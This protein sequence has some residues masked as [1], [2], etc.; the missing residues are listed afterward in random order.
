MFPQNVY[1]VIL[2]FTEFLTARET[3]VA[4]VN[5]IILTVITN[6][7]VYSD[8]SQVH[9]VFNCLVSEGVYKERNMV[10]YRDKL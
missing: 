10:A 7:S 6:L 5:A 8:I 3:A 1:A 2:H 4:V 9:N